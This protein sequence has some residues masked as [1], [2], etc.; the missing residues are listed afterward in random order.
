MCPLPVPLEGGATR[1]NLTQPASLGAQGSVLLV[2]ALPPN[3]VVTSVARLH[4]YV[5]RSA[6]V[7][8]FEVFE[9]G[10]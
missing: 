6:F 8:P 7:V 4:I 5:I 2:A 1:T 3:S 10:G 9:A